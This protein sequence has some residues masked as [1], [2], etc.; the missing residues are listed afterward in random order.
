MYRVNKKPKTPNIIWDPD[1]GCV[2]CRF[3]GGVFE[4]A[5]KKTADRLKKLGYEIETIAEENLSERASADD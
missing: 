2:L 5:D 1:T 3:K 4:T